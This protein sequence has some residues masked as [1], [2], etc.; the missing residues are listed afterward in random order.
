MYESEQPTRDD[1]WDADDFADLA[2]YDALMNDP[3]INDAAYD[4]YGDMYPHDEHVG[5]DEPEGY[6]S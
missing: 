4:S 5:L 3:P 2:T 6:G 1:D